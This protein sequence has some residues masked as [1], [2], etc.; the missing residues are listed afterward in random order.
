MTGVVSSA[1]DAGANVRWEIFLLMLLLISINYIDRASLSIA[2]PIIGKE[3]DLDPATQ[4][5]ILSSFFW[6]F[7]FMQVPGGAVFRSPFGI[8]T[9]LTT[10]SIFSVAYVKDPVVVVALLSTTLFFLRWCGMSW[11]I[12]SILAGRERAGLLGGG[13]MREVSPGDRHRSR[14]VKKLGPAVRPR[15]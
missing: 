14:R 8:A 12:P 11:A 4:G 13:N 9:I 2:M 6:T 15:S 7:A 3:F 5:L 10:I 1:V